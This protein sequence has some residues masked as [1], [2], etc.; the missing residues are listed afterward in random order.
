MTNVDPDWMGNT[1][2]VGDLAVGMSTT[3]DVDLMISDTFQGTSLVNNAEITEA[4]NALDIE[5]EDGAIGTINGGVAGDESELGTDND[6][7]DDGAGTPGTA[8]NGS[9]VD[10]YDPAQIDVVQTF[11]LALKK[12]I[13]TNQTPGPFGPGDQVQFYITVINQGTLDAYDVDIVDNAPIGLSAPTLVGGGAIGA[14]QNAPGDFS[15]AFIPAGASRTIRVRSFI[16]ANF[17]GT[18]LVNDAEITGASDI[19][20]GPDA[21][22]VDSTPGDLSLIHI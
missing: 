3:V 18:S 17:Q 11:D 10:D 15:I 2:L 22:D 1:F 6:I 19:D 5:D 13:N 16:D 4:S 12:V 8:D 21:L 9:D 7:D 14:T 20:G